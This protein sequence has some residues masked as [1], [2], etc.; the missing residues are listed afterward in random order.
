MKSIRDTLVPLAFCATVLEV[1]RK[2]QNYMRANWQRMLIAAIIVV[3][4]AAGAFPEPLMAGPLM[5]APFMVG[6]TSVADLK[7]LLMEQGQAWEEFK[8]TNDKAIKEGRTELGEVKE[9]FATMNTALDRFQ[10]ALQEV[11]ARTQRMLLDSSETGLVDAKGNKIVRLSAEEKAHKAAFVAFV[12]KGQDNGLAELEAKAMTV[13]SDPDGGYLVPRD[14]SG[15]MIL[16]IFETS[17]IRQYASVQAISTDALEGPNDLNDGVSGGWVTETG[18]R[19]TTNTPQVGKWR[20]PVHEQYAYPLASQSLLDDAAV[21]VESWLMGKTT[22]KMAR[23]ENTAFFTGTGNGQ[24][25][26]LMTYTTAATA[27]ASRAWQVFE[28]VATGSSG[29]FGTAPNGV[30]K[31]VDLIHKQKVAYRTNA[32]FWMSRSTLGETRKLKDGVGNYVWLPNTSVERSIA[33][34]ALPASTLLGY[35]VVEAEDMPVIGAGSLSIGFGDMA[36]TYQIVDR[37]GFRVLRDP[38]SNKPYVG[39]YVT[40]RVGGDALHFETFKF[41]KFS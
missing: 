20:I 19:A 36:R 7:N 32:K 26:G 16:K 40:R 39:F 3:A 31:L 9:K 11:E 41:L 34:S 29:S 23:T 15:Q 1:D 33:G 22:D 4:L 8:K 25:R 10:K 13:G 28:H 30:D 12:R 18:T 5:A 37:V 2:V 27:D 14:T 35:P 6:D 21:D 17:P 38:F 24:P